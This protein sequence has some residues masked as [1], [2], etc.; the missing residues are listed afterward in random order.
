MT[1][2]SFIYFSSSKQDFDKRVK[3]AN[4]DPKL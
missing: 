2:E 4:I 1:N 3:Y